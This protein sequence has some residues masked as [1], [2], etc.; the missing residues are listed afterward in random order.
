VRCQPP[1]TDDRRVTRRREGRARSAE[2]GGGAV[3]GGQPLAFF[4]PP[5]QQ[6]PGGYTPTA[7]SAAAVEVDTTGVVGPADVTAWVVCAAP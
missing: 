5:D 2:K 6:P 1:G 4:S 3:K 7:W